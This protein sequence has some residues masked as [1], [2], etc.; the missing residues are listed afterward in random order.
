MV[1]AKE[2]NVPLPD[3]LA[4]V[5]TVWQEVPDL[6]YYFKNIEDKLFEGT[7]RDLTYLEISGKLSMEWYTKKD[8]LS[9]RTAGPQA[10]RS[11]SATM[12]PSYFRLKAPEFPE[13]EDPDDTADIAEPQ[14]DKDKGKEVSQPRRNEAIPWE[15]K[16][17]P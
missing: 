17:R 15:A 1:Q 14:D 4:E 10:S 3:W 5:S 2:Y 9:L 8:R 12:T 16:M 11:V 6:S 13:E 7:A